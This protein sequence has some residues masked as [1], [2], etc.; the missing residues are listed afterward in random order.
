MQQVLQPIEDRL[1]V[2]EARLRHVQADVKRVKLFYSCIICISE[3][4]LAHKL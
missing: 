3:P 2:I 1:D 4:F